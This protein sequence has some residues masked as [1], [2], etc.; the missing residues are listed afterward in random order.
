MRAGEGGQ[1]RRRERKKKR[2][3]EVGSEGGKEG[4][5]LEEMFSRKTNT[6]GLKKTQQITDESKIVHYMQLA[7]CQP[8]YNRRIFLEM[9]QQIRTQRATLNRAA[10]IVLGYPVGKAL[11]MV[12]VS[13]TI[14]RHKYFVVGCVVFVI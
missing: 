5:T 3:G 6:T 9:L 14:H 13:A 1:G 10:K 8:Q 11:P 7:S 2:E 4:G 12:R